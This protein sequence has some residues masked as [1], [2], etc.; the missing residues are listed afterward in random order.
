M[1]LELGLTITWAKLHP[2]RHTWFLWESTPRRLQKSMSD[3]DGTDPYIHRGT[4]QGVL[5]ELRKAFL[6]EGAPPV[7]RMI[8]AYRLVESSL[9]GVLADPGSSSLYTAS[10]FK[11]LC[12]LA[13]DAAGGAQEP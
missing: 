13:L 8:E 5:S 9:D 3:L 10:V 7:N 4:V 11:E 1:P 2:K 12:F 6:R